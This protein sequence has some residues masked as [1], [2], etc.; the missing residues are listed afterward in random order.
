MSLLFAF[1]L[2]IIFYLL[3]QKFKHNAAPHLLAKV[4]K[5]ALITGVAIALFAG[6]RFGL[7]YIIPIIIGSYALFGKFSQLVYYTKL[8]ARLFGFGKKIRATE[9]KDPGPSFV[10]S[11][12]MTLSEA[13]EIL[14]VA[15]NAT[16]DEIKTAYNKLMKQYHP[17]VGGQEYFAAKLNMAKELLLKKTK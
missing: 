17:D 9:H 2:V 12:N 6:L 13:Q 8:V 11:N 14:N 10:G 15:Q 5:T 7:P 4:R 16:D 3:W 1:F